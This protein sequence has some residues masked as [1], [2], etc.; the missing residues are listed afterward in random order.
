M[1]QVFLVHYLKLTWDMQS[2]IFRGEHKRMCCEN[3]V[4]VPCDWSL[5]ANQSASEKHNQEKKAHTPLRTS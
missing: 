5:P 3:D 4:I 1:G 2:V